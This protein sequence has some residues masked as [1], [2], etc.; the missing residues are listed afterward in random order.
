MIESGAVAGPAKISFLWV[1]YP[2]PDRRAGGV[3]DRQPYIPSAFTGGSGVIVYRPYSL[4]L[5]YDYG[6]GNDSIAAASS[7]GFITDAS[8]YAVRLDYA[9]AANLNAY[10]TILYAYRISQGY[11]WGW[12]RPNPSTAPVSPAL[13]YGIQGPLQAFTELSFDPVPG[14]PRAPN[15]LERDLGYEFGLGF[16]WKLIEGYTLRARMAYWKP[17]GWFKFACVDRTQLNWD[18]PN[19][20]NMWGINPNREIAPIFGTHVTINIDF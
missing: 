8:T 11:G 20:G 2:G 3:I 7:H 14:G 10:A 19:A 18:Q 1:Y 4:L 13:E 16:D 6:S 17:G 15:I 9:M 5:G 12:I